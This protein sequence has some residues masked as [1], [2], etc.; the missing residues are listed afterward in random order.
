MRAG[1]GSRGRALHSFRQDSRAAARVHARAESRVGEARYAR[2]SPQPQEAREP[3]EDLSP[4]YA[5]QPT[6]AVLLAVTRSPSRAVRF[7]GPDPMLDESAI[8][9]RCAPAPLHFRS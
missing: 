4:T 9:F 1:Y 8:S 2:E 6:V 7:R 3:R 5:S